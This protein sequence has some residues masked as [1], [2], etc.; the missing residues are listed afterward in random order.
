[1]T[2]EIMLPYEPVTKFN[3][4]L[5]TPY[6]CR[7]LPPPPLVTITYVP[8]IVGTPTLKLP[9]PPIQLGPVFI[10]TLF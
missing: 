10:M 2:I 3:P 4:C 6:P 7:L 5:L 9:P 8:S 1:M